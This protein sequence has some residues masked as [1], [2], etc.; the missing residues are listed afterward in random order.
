V[1]Q[2]KLPENIFKTIEK[3]SLIFGL[4]QEC[5]PQ[6]SAKASTN[7]LYISR[8]RS[9]Q[10]NVAFSTKKLKGGTMSQRIFSNHQINYL[11]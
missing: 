5:V 7:N 10:L 11:F 3:S 6:T 4:D 2:K 9:N 8:H 1:K